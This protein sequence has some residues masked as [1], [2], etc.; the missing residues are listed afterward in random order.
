MVKCLLCEHNVPLGN[1][2][3]ECGE[4][5]LGG[6]SILEIP[7]QKFAELTNCASCRTLTPGQKYCL[8]CGAD[9]RLHEDDVGVEVYSSVWAFFLEAKDR[10]LD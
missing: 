4:G 8:N 5:E 7:E 10:R 1:Y 6:V 2:C 3:I 9:L